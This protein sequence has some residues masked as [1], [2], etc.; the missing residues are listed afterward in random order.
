MKEKGED[1]RKSSRAGLASD[2]QGIS[3]LMSSE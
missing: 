2:D 1:L 3:N